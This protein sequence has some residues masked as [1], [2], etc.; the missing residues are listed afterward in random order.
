MTNRMISPIARAL[1]CAAFFFILM[2]MAFAAMPAPAN[3]PTIVKAFD[4]T[5]IPLNGSAGL[6]F[7]I[8][9]T[10]ATATIN[11]VAFTDSLPDGLV[12][13]TPGNLSSTCTGT[14]TAADGS[15]SVSL[16][17]ASLDPG[18]SCVVSLTVTGTTAGSKDNSVT[19][20]STD[21]GTGNTSSASLT[22]TAAL[23]PTISKIFLPD[24]IAAG[25][26]TLLSFTISNPNSDPNTNV[27]LTGIQ[28]TDVLPA[29]VVVASP[30]QLSNSCDGTV[31]ATPGSGTITLS[32]GDLGPAVGLSPVRK[33]KALAP[34]RFD[35][36][37]SGSCFISV[38]VTAATSGVYNN[39]TGPISANES[40]AGDP[41][42]TATLTVTASSQVVPPT[43]AK[44]FADATIPVGGTTVLTFS[45]SNPNTS[46]DLLNISFGDPLPS[47]LVVASPNGLTGTCA[48]AISAS[49]GSNVI[50]MNSLT[51]VAN[52]NCSFSVSVTATNGGNKL[53]T[54]SAVTAIYDSGSGNFFPTVTGGTAS[55]SIFV[56]LP[57]T[58]SKAFSPI[59]IAPTGVSTLAFTL[60]NPAANPV[61]ASGVAFTDT[62]PA[63]VVVATP[64]GATNTCG[65]TLTATAG[66]NS[67]SLSGGTIAIS[68]ACSI[69]VNVTSA[70]PGA[71]V[72]TTGPVSSANGGT[73]NT[74]TATLFVKRASL[75][76]T[77]THNGD[78]ERR[79]QGATYTIVV[80]DD[81][82]AGPTIGDVTVVDTLPDVEHTLQPTA[83]G[84]AGWTCSLATLTCTRNDQLA[85][86]AS[87]PPITLTVD[88]PQNIRA[89]VVNSATVSGGGD[90][91]T[92][93]ANDPTHIGPPDNGNP[94]KPDGPGRR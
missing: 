46:T 49:P 83:I 3:P 75:I 84:G 17:D 70:V 12:V 64:N 5:M 74:A 67:I 1:V 47:G 93:T 51:L 8:T 69:T 44:A 91:N 86:G 29:G 48:A 92:H 81:P 56:I 13:A 57:P 11:G 59:L 45:L 71:Y 2:N 20:T 27:T 32:G 72:N 39:A 54:T 50:S 38:E 18:A 19:V 79:Q 73:G 80:S 42:N 35:P 53:N 7:T 22:V 55:A 25:G 76:I 40:G 58:I 77:K 34:T 89:N 82:N 65:G 41:S 26:Q 88:V 63:N 87:Y 16:A 90:L 37:S 94:D 61:A 24:T 68:G 21:A 30:N 28:F 66:S 62:L 43:I 15:S 33:V 14:A 9:N 31:T 36:T 78:F 60:V 6:S 10:D 85:P 23:P 4:T 52:S